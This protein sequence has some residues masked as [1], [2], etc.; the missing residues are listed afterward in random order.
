MMLLGVLE[1]ESFFSPFGLEK[2][3]AKGGQ[4]GMTLGFVEGERE[5]FFF[6]RVISV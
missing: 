6:H 1:D 4:L 3:S 5:G 2:A